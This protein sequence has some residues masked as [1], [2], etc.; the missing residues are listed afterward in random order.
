MDHTLSTNPKR[1]IR[2]GIIGAGSVAQIIHLPTLQLMS[3][4][5]KVTALCDVSRQ[6]LDHCGSKFGLGSDR[7][8]EKS[9]DLVKRDDVDLVAILSA[10]EYHLPHLIEAADAGKHV[11]IEKP[12]ALTNEDANAIIAAQKRN[13]VIVFVGYMRRYAPAFVEAVKIVRSI[14]KIDYARNPYFISQSGSF[15]QVFGDIPKAFAN[16]FLAQAQAIA[17]S[18]LGAKRAQD[19]GLVDTY[20]LLTSLGSHD[21]SAMRELI[22]MPKRCIGA[23]KNADG[24]FLT[25]LFEYDGFITTYETGID[26]VGKF[27]A[28]LEVHGEGKRIKVT[29]DTP[30]A[31]LRGDIP[32]VGAPSGYNRLINDERVFRAF[33]TFGIHPS[34]SEGLP[35]TLTV[36]ETNSDGHFQERVVRPTYQD[37]YTCEYESLYESIVNGAPV[38]T[39]AEDA[40]LDLEVF[41]MIMDAL[42]P[43][44]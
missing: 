35:I 36:L 19:P 22:G 21:L 4:K 23:G 42:A 31:L 30:F 32:K 25:A 43:A 34:R 2:V 16:D 33:P 8:H 1:V 29:Y 7:L 40:K 26:N 37:A 20:R 14:K 44:T 24:S 5:Y 11:L 10:D 39:T 13:G 27:D 3:D 12:M 28:H 18:A 41:G 17:T 15:P 38:K 9:I 6:A